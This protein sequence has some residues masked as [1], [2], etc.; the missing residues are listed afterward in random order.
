MNP[1][2]SG[3]LYSCNASCQLLLLFRSNSFYSAWMTKIE[4]AFFP[5]K[6]AGCIL[7]ED[8]P[9]QT[10]ERDCRNSIPCCNS[11]PLSFPSG[12]ENPRHLLGKMTVCLCRRWSECTALISWKIKWLLGPG[13]ICDFYWENLIPCITYLD[14]Y[15][16]HARVHT[17]SLLPTSGHLNYCNPD[18]PCSKCSMW[19]KQFLKSGLHDILGDI[20]LNIWFIQIT[21]CS[22]TVKKLFGTYA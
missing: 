17:L 21:W 20:P 18:M 15:G 13:A 3:Q 9:C 19:L 12:G 5:Q 7:W 8:T 6:A 14:T 22:T 10:W 2:D 16:W 11:I 4:L 1:D